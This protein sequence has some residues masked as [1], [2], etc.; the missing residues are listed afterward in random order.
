MVRKAVLPVAGFGSRMLPAS[1]SIP[2]EMLPIVDR[3]AIEYVV[4]EAVRAGIKEIILVSHSAK[5]AIE[6]YFDTQFELEQQ[7]AEKGKD[8]L[9]A[10][11]RD[12]LPDD[13]SVISVRQHR[14]LGLGHAVACAAPVVGYEPFAVLLPDVLVDCEGEAE[15]LGL[16]VAAYGTSGAAQIMVEEVPAERVDQYGIVAL[17]G[18]VPLPGESSAMTAVVEKPAVEDAPSRLSVVGRYVLPGEIMA[19]LAETPPGAGNEIQLTDAIATL[20]QRAPVEAYAM[21]GRTFDCGN[22]AGYLQA[23]FH[24]AAR[25]PEL[26]EQVRAMMAAELGEAGAS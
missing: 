24:Y 20:M 16:M 18:G 5:T 15:D 8:A 2:K 12:I 21:R 11:V 7:L 6:D 23:V 14:A 13:V 10:E 3:P 25:H 4:K 26:G 19:I 1:K 22:K 9:L 17:K